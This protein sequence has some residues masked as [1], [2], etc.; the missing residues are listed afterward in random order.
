[1]DEH[2]STNTMPLELP[3]D[4]VPTKG[5]WPVSAIVGVITAGVLAAVT[6]ALAAVGTAY[7]N[8][9]IR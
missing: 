8:G 3:D 7:A 5:S 9:W 1:M 2:E 4:L 6:V